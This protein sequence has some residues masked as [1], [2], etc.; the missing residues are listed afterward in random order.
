MSRPADDCS[1]VIPTVGREILWQA[2]ERIAHGDALPR[3]VVVADQGGNL[4]FEDWWPRLARH[5]L[6]LCVVR[7]RATGR[8]SAVNAGI[9]AAGTRFVAITDDDCVPAH[10]WVAA[11]VARLRAS[12]GAIVSGS[13][14]TIGVKPNV[15]T[16][17][18]R[19][20]RLVTSPSLTFD[21]MSGGNVGFSVET[22]ERVG[23]F[24]EHPSVR[25]AEDGDWAYRA[26]REGVPILYAPEVRVAHAAWRSEEERRDRYRTYALSQAGFYGKHIRRGDGF[27]ALRAAANTARA[28]RRWLRGVVRGDREARMHGAAY[29][30]YFLPGVV[31]GLRRAPEAR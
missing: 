6:E 23:P 26:L 10:D 28:A 8:S 25:A 4:P 21:P 19:A 16:V 9:R 30:R 18:R 11:M 31:A 2:L 15:D 20:E 27:M 22:F 17:N 5:D 12:P 24:D 14:G 7:D 1:V 29:V 13:V 3:R